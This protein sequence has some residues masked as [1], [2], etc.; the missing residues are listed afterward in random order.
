VPS[1][2]DLARSKPAQG[3]QRKRHL[4][5]DRQRRVAG[6][7]DELRRWSGNVVVF[8]DPSVQLPA[9]SRPAPGGEGPRHASSWGRRR[10]ATRSAAMAKDLS[11]GFLGQVKIAEEANQGGQDSAL[12]KILPQAAFSMQ[13]KANHAKTHR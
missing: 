2:R 9:V 10:G 4:R 13:C 11:G 8:I 1:A 3:A 5:L 12:R 7:E 6:G